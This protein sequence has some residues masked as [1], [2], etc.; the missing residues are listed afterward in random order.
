MLGYRGMMVFV[1][2]SEEELG[3]RKSLETEMKVQ[4]GE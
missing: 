1:D 3:R 4:L 2:V